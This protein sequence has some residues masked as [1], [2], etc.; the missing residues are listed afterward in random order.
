MFNVTKGEK[1]KNLMLGLALG[2]SLSAF[3]ENT[4]INGTVQSRCIISTDTE[5][6]Y[7]N[8]NAY[9]LTTAPA[10][11]GVL[12]VTRFDVTLADAYYAQITAPSSFSTAPSL[13]DVVTWTGDTEVSAVSDS[14]NMADY[15]TDKVEYDYTD[16]Y[17]LTA[18]GSTWFKTSSTATMG[19]S[20]AFPGGNYTAV[21]EAV[22]IAQ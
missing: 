4:S 15:E 2:L 8:P 12:A 19:G 22:C 7:G 14:T 5:G 6:T 21:V 1:M 3:A 17:D 9:T 13:P 10:D 11:G 16:K 18:T 20:K